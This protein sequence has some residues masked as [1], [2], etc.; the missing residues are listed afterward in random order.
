[1]L[2]G[3]GIAFTAV[4]FQAL[5]GRPFS[6]NW[7]HFKDRADLG[8]ELAFRAEISGRFRE[9]FDEGLEVH[10][11]AVTVLRQLTARGVPI[12]VVSSSTRDHVE[13]VLARAEVGTL[14][15]HIVA[16]G[17]TLAHKPDP[18]PY[19]A[20]CRSLDVAPERSVAV[21]DTTTG[22]RSARAAGLWTVA[23]RREHAVPELSLHADAVVDELRLTDVVAFP[24]RRRGMPHR[25]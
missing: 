20:A 19:V 21:E 25:R 6:D 22:A 18:E 12:A 16:S 17:D 13:R 14:V 15:A 23:V 11:D 10:E 7:A 8:D 5:V 3:Y 24:A 2:S 1:V 9:L 4:D